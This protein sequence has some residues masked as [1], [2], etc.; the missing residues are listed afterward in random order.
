M[1]RILQ[2][3]T[4]QQALKANFTGKAPLPVLLWALVDDEGKTYLAG[5]VM[6]PETKQIV[7]ADEMDGF[8]GYT[9]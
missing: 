2:I 1:S 3:A 5:M 6:N 4:G 9:L 8:R 7:R